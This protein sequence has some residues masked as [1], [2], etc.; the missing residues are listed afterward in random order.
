M[1]VLMGVVS[2]FGKSKTEKFKVF[3]ECGMCETRIEKA[4][5]GVDGVSSADWDK[6]T[7][8][9]EVTFDESKTEIQKI[10][11]AIAKAGHD[12]DAHKATS[13]AYSE[14]PG[15]CKYDRPTECKKAKKSSDCSKE[16]K[17]SED[18]SKKD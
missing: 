3:G 7:K 9:M 16:H 15:C 12:T 14:L 11:K 8:M 1:V 17:K 13:D 5:N 4:A 6:E 10:H 2:S 18:C